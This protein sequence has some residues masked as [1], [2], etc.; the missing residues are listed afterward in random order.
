MSKSL[1]PLEKVSFKVI[2]WVGTPYSVIFHTLLFMGIPALG[3]F[4]F[5]LRSILLMF[6][7]WLSIEAIYLAIFIQMSVNRNT[8]SLEEVEEDIE[9]IQEEASEE[10]EA[11]KVL[12]HIG[13]QMKSI[14]HEI[15]VLKRSGVLKHNG[16]GHRKI[17]A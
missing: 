10:E 4:G 7:T 14:Q 6:T 11:H 15:D 13:Q 2:R 1:A 8:E 12:I 17:E 3:F 16:N 5:E 9:D